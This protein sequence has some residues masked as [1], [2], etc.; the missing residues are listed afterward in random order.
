MGAVSL[1]GITCI[2]DNFDSWKR[3]EI[4]ALAILMK[5]LNLA[6]T[7]RAANQHFDDEHFFSENG[8]SC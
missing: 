4:L 2:N 1:E 7:P 8:S 6:S 3:Q 5:C